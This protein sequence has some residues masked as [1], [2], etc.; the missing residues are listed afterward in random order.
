MKLVDRVVSTAAST[1]GSQHLPPPSRGQATSA[2][3]FPD[4]AGNAAQVVSQGVPDS[5]QRWQQLLDRL[6]SVRSLARTYDR[7][8]D[9]LQASSTAAALTSSP[10]QC[11]WHPSAGMCVCVCPIL[12]GLIL[13]YGGICSA[14]SHICSSGKGPLYGS[15]TVQVQGYAAKKS[16]LV[17]P[18]GRPWRGASGRMPGALLFGSLA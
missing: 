2:T 16:L 1:L 6:P 8:A 10:G 4:W 15:C 5:Q 13:H 18:R 11:D 3:A 12:V 9:V 14:G 7:V 17:A